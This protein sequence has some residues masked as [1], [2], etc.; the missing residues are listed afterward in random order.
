MDPIYLL[1]ERLSTEFLFRIETHL[2]EPDDPQEDSWILDIIFDDHLV[3]IV[4][5]RPDHKFEIYDPTEESLDN[6]CGF[7]SFNLNEVFQQIG[8]IIRDKMMEDKLGDAWQ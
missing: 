6:S 7:S 1:R 2:E 5:W 8:E 3:G 4:K